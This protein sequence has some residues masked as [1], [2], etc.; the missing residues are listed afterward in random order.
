MTTRHDGPCHATT[1]VAP[2]LGAVGLLAGARLD[3]G[4]FGLAALAD[5]CSTALPSWVATLGYRIA[6]APWSYGGM[7]AGCTAGLLLAAHRGAVGH[8]CGPVRVA[9]LVVCIAGMLLG[10]VVIERLSLD[11]WP[12]FANLPAAART[13][14]TM[15]LGMSVG[16]WLAGSLVD[17]LAG[18]GLREFACRVATS[19]WRADGRER[20]RTRPAARLSRAAMGV[21]SIAPIECR[22]FPKSIREDIR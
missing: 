7:L 2:L 1:A 8:R 22:S 21:Y 20:D 10:M 6:A 17:S 18:G 3:F 19:S 16:M 12:A 14:A 11:V 13:L 15:T 4:Q 5:L 9:R